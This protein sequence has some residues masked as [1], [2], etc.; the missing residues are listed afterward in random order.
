[1]FTIQKR[2]T[3][4]WINGSLKSDGWYDTV[5]SYP[6]T[7]RTALGVKTPGWPK[8]QQDG[9]LI[10]NP[11]TLDIVHVSAPP[12]YVLHTSDCPPQ[13]GKSNVHT[14]IET[15]FSLGEASAYFGGS[16]T[17]IPPDTWAINPE[18]LKRKAFE[19]S[20]QEDWNVA[21]MVAEGHETLAM[22]VSLYKLAKNPTKSLTD[23]FIAACKN[24][25]L[26]RL[27]TP[28]G[29]AFDKT[30]SAWLT[31]RYGLKPLISDIES[32][33]DF[34][35]KRWKLK[36]RAA[37]R[38]N[39]GGDR[40]FSRSLVS[41][42]RN[43]LG[44]SGIPYGTRLV[45]ESNTESRKDKCVITS[46]YEFENYMALFT[47]RL[48]LRASQAPLLVWEKIPFS[49]VVDWFVDI[50]SWLSEIREPVGLVER[51]GTYSIRLDA[52]TKLVGIDSQWTSTD[53]SNCNW[54]Q[55]NNWINDSDGE[56]K[57]FH[58]DR[59]VFDA[60]SPQSVPGWG[61][62]MDLIRQADA[63]ALIFLGCRRKLRSVSTN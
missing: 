24:R 3:R 58:Y 51:V 36:Y 6:D 41:F 1:M 4:I 31:Y 5:V 18:A 38:P 50:G 39:Q 11:Y 49:F 22:L 56:N 2:G 20:N 14:R 60:R 17:G 52:D 62:G 43:P 19:K 54:S 63:A 10:V 26:N 27:T 37:K 33:V 15:Y 46:D 40:S 29:M 34:A 45:E 23:M 55:S 9:A 25:G 53:S 7:G 16:W 57:S 32:A 28:L 59:Q 47:D 48:G 35:K 42:N 44:S 21:V 8:P 13:E 61:Q 12:P 30:S